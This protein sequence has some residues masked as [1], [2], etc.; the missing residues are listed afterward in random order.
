MRFALTYFYLVMALLLVAQVPNYEFEEWENFEMPTLKNWSVLGNVKQA[1]DAT[2]NLFAIQLHNKKADGSFGVVANTNLA[3]GLSGGTPYTD[4]PFVMRFD[5]KYNL[6]LEDT[7][8]IIAYFKVAGQFNAQVN[9]KVTGNSADT[10]VRIKYP[11]QWVISAAPDSVVLV[12]SSHTFE[13]P[14]QG[15][16]SII[17]DNLIFET[18]GNPDDQLPNNNFESWDITK[19]PYP[20]AWYTTNLFVHDF[21]NVQTDI[22]A[23]VASNF[24]HYKTS[25]SLRN[26]KLGNDLLPGIAITGNTFNDKFPPAFPVSTRWQYLQ[27]YYGF[28]PDKNDTGMVAV[29]MYNKGQLIGAGQLGFVSPASG[30]PYFSV[31]ITYYLPVN[32]DSACIVL[33][34]A[35]INNPKGEKTELWIDKLSFSNRIASVQDKN[36]SFSIY[37]NPATNELFIQS[38]GENYLYQIYDNLGKLVLT[39]EQQEIYIGD[40]KSGCYTLFARNNNRILSHKFIKL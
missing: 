27:G 8:N 19:I 20:K 40:I 6:A 28:T 32:P 34:S 14:V 38:N 36:I 24:A 13:T 12:L 3:A 30:I 4:M 9:F 1:S 7:A 35:A 39:S 21:Y 22:K 10:F 15:D 37:P 11:I 2:S 17:V 33:S 23:V 31:P 29:L 18:F 25:I 26:T 5:I 16:G